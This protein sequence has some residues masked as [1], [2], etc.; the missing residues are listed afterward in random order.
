[1][2]CMY[3]A[4]TP[5]RKAP[6]ASRF[7]RLAAS[8]NQS[9]GGWTHHMSPRLPLQPIYIL[10]SERFGLYVYVFLQILMVR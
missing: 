1:M 8:L 9:V 5:L 4:L 2:S 3:L 6:R 7:L 10:R